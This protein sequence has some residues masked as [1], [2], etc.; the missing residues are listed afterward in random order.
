MLANEMYQNKAQTNEQKESG[1]KIFGSIEIHGENVN[2][3][4]Q[5]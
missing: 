3:N 2:S 4:I 5:Y 1:N